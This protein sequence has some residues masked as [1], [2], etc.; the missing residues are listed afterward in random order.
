MADAAPPPK[1]AY[2]ES[3]ER[4]RRRATQAS[5]AKQADVEAA[6]LVPPQGD[7]KKVAIAENKARDIAKFGGKGKSERAKIVQA[8]NKAAADVQDMLSPAPAAPPTV[9]L[10]PGT[11]PSLLDQRRFNKAHSNAE[12]DEINDAARAAGRAVR[13]TLNGRS[14]RD[15]HTRQR[16]IEQANAAMAA[17]RVKAPVPDQPKT[18]V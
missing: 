2:R 16:R 9:A 3:A 11:T 18:G 6:T 1:P 17:A 7:E 8:D 15:R 10:V 13:D 4:V 12:R 14:P 5:N